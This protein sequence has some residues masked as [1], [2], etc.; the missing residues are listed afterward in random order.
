ML[1]DLPGWIPGQN[2][3]VKQKSQMRHKL[4]KIR[5]VYTRDSR[6]Y[7]RD[8]LCIHKRSLV[9]TQE[10]L[11]CIHKRISCVYTRDFDEILTIFW[12]L[13]DSHI[14][15][16][17]PSRKVREGLRSIINPLKTYCF[18]SMFLNILG[19]GIAYYCL[20]LPAEWSYG[21][22]NVLQNRQH[23]GELVPR[24]GLLHAIGTKNLLQWIGNTR[25]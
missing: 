4:V 10:N 13:F 19:I 2:M 22:P 15:T 16:R 23:V 17:D 18:P 3:T 9:C 20:L 1:P 5:C 24:A 7:T 25:Q 12:L 6:V 14:L 8:L 21:G 11:L